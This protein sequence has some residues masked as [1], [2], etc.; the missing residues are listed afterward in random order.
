MKKK[1][2]IVDDILS[3]KSFSQALLIS[4]LGD[5]GDNVFKWAIACSII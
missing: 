1:A 2:I 4:Q 5:T 3:S